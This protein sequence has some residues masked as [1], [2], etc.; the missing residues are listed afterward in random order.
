MLVPI[1][2][3]DDP[4]QCLL[5]RTTPAVGWIAAD[6]AADVHQPPD[7][8][9][10]HREELEDTQQVEPRSQYTVLKFSFG[11]TVHPSYVY[12]RHCRQYFYFSLQP[13]HLP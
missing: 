10:P 3:A 9:P 5:E 8:E 6:V 4:C 2:R 11:I 7:E 13:S 1:A 12:N